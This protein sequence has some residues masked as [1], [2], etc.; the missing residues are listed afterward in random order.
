M[1]RNA[2]TGGFQDDDPAY[3]RTGDDLLEVIC[4]EIIWEE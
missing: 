3:P 4:Y 1:V 2:S